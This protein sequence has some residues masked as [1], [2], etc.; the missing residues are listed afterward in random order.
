MSKLVYLVEESGYYSEGDRHLPKECH[1]ITHVCA[2]KELAKQWLSKWIDEYNPL[3][4]DIS[5]Y[6]AVC[7][8]DEVPW[9]LAD[10]KM[11]EDFKTNEKDYVNGGSYG[12]IETCNFYSMELEE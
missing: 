1:T 10:M 4:E 12:S 5:D 7:Y 2:T 3:P 6:E 11:M 8:Y 9:K